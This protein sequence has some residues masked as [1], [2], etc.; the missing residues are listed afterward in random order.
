MPVNVLP[1]VGY[2]SRGEFSQR[3]YPW[4]ELKPL[5][6]AGRR[7]DAKERGTLDDVLGE[8]YRQGR[9]FG[10]LFGGDCTGGFSLTLLDSLD[11]LAL[12][13]DLHS[14]R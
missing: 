9:D 12:T 3:G 5:S 7:W 4:D 6:C 14:F 1:P 13:G 10:I 8:R 2:T 11:T